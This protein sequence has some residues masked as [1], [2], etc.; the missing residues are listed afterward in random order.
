VEV[1]ITK[2]GDGPESKLTMA[3]PR[4]TN[5]PQV[6]ILHATGANRDREA[7]QAIAQASGQPR[8]FFPWQ[9]PRRTRGENGH[10]GLALFSQGVRYA[11]EL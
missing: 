1:K 7:A 4:K 6:L 8:I 3:L 11:A 2:P 9:H 10:L 5:P